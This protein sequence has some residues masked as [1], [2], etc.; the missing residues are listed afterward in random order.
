MAVTAWSITQSGRFEPFDLQVGRGQISWHRNVFKFGIIASVQTTPQNIWNAGV[1]YVFPAAAIQM[2][3]SSSSAA[4]ASPSGTG[5]QTV[6]IQ[7]LDADYNEI[8]ETIALTGQ[9]AVTTVNSYLR[10]NNFEVVSV[11]SGGTAAG[12]LYVGTGTVTSGVPATIYSQIV[13]L[14]NAC[15]EAIFTVPAG[16]TAYVSSYTFTSGYGNATPV[17]CSGFL[18]YSKNGFFEIQASARMNSGNAFDRHFDVP[19]AV[20]EKKD[21]VLKAS[22]GTGSVVSMTGEMHILLIKNDANA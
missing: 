18:T 21:I 13:L 8:S 19:F 9:T 17:L 22:A 20:A 3:V 12:T 2:K 1:E 10:I 4:D 11:G 5:A 14:Y 7:G 6:L 15:T 16:Y